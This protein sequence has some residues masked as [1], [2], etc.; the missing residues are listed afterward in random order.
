MGEGGLHGDVAMIKRPNAGATIGMANVKE[1]RRRWSVS[2][3]PRACV[4]DHCSVLLL[5]SLSDDAVCH[6]PKAH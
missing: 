1:R 2:W 5:P 4:G 3:H 6:S